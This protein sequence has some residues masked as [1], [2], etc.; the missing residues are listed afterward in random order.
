M[1]TRA[2]R[3]GSDSR[4]FL[5]AVTPARSSLCCVVAGIMCCLLPAKREDG[6]I[7]RASLE[8]EQRFPN[9]LGPRLGR[10]RAQRPG[11]CWGDETIHMSKSPPAPL[12]L[13]VKFLAL[14]LG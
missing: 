13:C 7:D 4:C 5:P 2:P 10:V 12:R 11:R 3:V 14:D 1:A 9:G 8:Q 6:G